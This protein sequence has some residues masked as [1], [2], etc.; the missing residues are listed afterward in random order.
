[1]DRR[2]V[3][4]GVTLGLALAL[5]VAWAVAAGVP[6]L[7]GAHGA[8]APDT[9]QTRVFRYL[10]GSAV[11]VEVYGGD[12]AVRRLAADEA[13]GAIDAVDREMSSYRADS[14]LSRVNRT[15]PA[16][17]VQVGRG[18]FAVLQAAARV[19]QASGGAFDITAAPLLDA[20]GLRDHHPR[21]PAAA[22][23]DRLRPSIG[24]RHVVLDPGARTVRF[25]ARDTRIDLGG[26][27]KG[28]AAELAA[29]A[30]TR[31]G[32]SGV[33]DTGSLQFMVGHPPGKAGWSV[34]IADPDNAGGLLGAIDVA[35]G[36]AATI[37]A[38]TS[39]G[40]APLDPRTMRPGRS[41]VSATVVSPDATLAGGLAGA[42]FILGPE[43]GLALLGQFGA[44]GVVGAAEN[45]RVRVHVS[46]GHEGEFHPAV[47]R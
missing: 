37:A 19:S 3:G 47:Y 32:L 6:T 43:K 13:I 20:W 1:M 45:G 34:G 25:A 40:A 10:M 29:G 27:A 31:R 4:I 38:G 15:A 44:W 21:V 23:L 30:L 35:G 33:I 41:A 46:G 28:F 16:G 42:V 7:I 9:G 11:R 26:L 12:T 17:P 2:R 22:E 24:F 39:P 18:L 36:A 5:A 8:E 14:D